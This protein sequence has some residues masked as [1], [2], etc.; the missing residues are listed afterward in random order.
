MYFCIYPSCEYNSDEEYTNNNDNDLCLI[1]WLPKE[2][3]NDIKLLTDFSNIK[4][5]CECNPKIHYLCLNDW[6]TK[7]KSC[8]ICRK[9]IKFVIVSSNNKNV[10]LYFF[11]EY[12]IY[13]LRILCYSSLINLFCL[14]FYNTYNIYLMI[15]TY[16]QDDYGTY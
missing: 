1:C 8:P 4:V 9:E 16:Y 2:K 14:L 10:I 5:N 12:I 3:N 11:T 13:F 7:T 6:I 15:N